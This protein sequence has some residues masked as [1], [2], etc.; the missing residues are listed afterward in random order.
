MAS[1][2]FWMGLDLIAESIRDSNKTKLPS[3]VI[4]GAVNE[5]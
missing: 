3:N 1:K 5:Y 4:Y 2:N